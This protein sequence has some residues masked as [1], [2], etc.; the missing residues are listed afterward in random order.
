MAIKLD[1]KTRRGR[2]LLWLAS[3]LLRLIL[4]I[5]G[6]TW[7]MRLVAG[8]DVYRRVL[9]EPSPSLLSFWHNRTVMAAIF[10]VRRFQRRGLDVALL[11]S[12]SRDGELVAGVANAWGLRVVRGSA[13]R[14]GREAMWGLYKAIRAGFSPAVV[15]DGPTGPVYQVK[16][17]ILYLAMT[18]GTPILPMGFATD[19]AW[20]IKSW[21]RLII[22]KPFAR[23]AVV[24]DDPRPVASKLDGEAFQAE[25]HATKELMDRLTLRAEEFVGGTFPD[26]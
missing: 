26:R 1:Q 13:T 18:T 7:R 17:G 21:D 22:P 24:L 6:R 10:L 12:Q 14:G 19:R 11:A 23:V 9:A 15:P 25:L 5:L 20:R 2:A 4:G 16:A 8:E 3:R